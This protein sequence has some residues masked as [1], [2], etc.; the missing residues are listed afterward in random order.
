[1]AGS[2]SHGGTQR[3]LAPRIAVHLVVIAALMAG[4]LPG[5]AGTALAAGGLASRSPSLPVS[6]PAPMPAPA[7]AS[8]H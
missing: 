2:L 8:T 4:A 6:F 1:M 5:Q 3:R 7:G